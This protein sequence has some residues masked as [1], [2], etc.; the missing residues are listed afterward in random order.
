MQLSTPKD[1]SSNVFSIFEKKLQ[2]DDDIVCDFLFDLCFA[3][4][5][6]DSHSLNNFIPNETLNEL[7][8]EF[9]VR[10]ISAFEC[11][12]ISINPTLLSA[13]DHLV[14]HIFIEISEKKTALETL[15]VFFNTIDEMLCKISSNVF[16]ILMHDIAKSSIKKMF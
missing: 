10:A 16:A 15:Y 4:R 6:N 13:N 11:I 5:R 7:R 3:L 1:Y 14:S 9:V 2:I 8:R 12:R